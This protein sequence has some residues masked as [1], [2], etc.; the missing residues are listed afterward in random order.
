M[1]IVYVEMSA[2]EQ[3]L[4]LDAVYNHIAMTYHEVVSADSL[5]STTPS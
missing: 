3:P 4:R 1:F 5:L 2:A